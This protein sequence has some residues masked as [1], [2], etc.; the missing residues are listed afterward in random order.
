MNQDK[1]NDTKT[2][3]EWVHRN[4][5]CN[6][7]NIEGE[8]DSMFGVTYVVQERFGN[9]YFK[10]TSSPFIDDIVSYLIERYKLLKDWLD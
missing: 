5:L 7:I 8:E 6:V 3:N 10:I 4:G 1:P 9:M 2:L